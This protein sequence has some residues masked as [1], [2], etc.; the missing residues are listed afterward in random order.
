[1]PR[2]SDEA[3]QAFAR[4][5]RSYKGALSLIEI[6]RRHRMHPGMVRRICRDYEVVLKSPLRGHRRPSPE[7]NERAQREQIAAARQS[8]RREIELA[9]AEA[10]TAPPYEGWRRDLA[11]AERWENRPSPVSTIGR[12]PRSLF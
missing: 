7:I 3:R 8:L 12:E 10:A 9:R 6:S 5:F 1:M 2:L 11:D 4:K